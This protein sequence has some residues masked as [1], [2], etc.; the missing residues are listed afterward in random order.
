MIIAFHALFET[1]GSDSLA[2]RAILKEHKR[3][4]F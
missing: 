1:E 4:R 2:F 3:D